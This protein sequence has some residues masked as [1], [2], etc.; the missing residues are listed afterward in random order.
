MLFYLFAFIEIGFLTGFI[1]MYVGTLKKDIN[2][3]KQRWVK[4]FF[5]FIIVHIVVLFALMSKIYITGLMIIVIL[6]SAFEFTRAWISKKN[7]RPN[8][9]IIITGN[10]VLLIL[11][12]S[13]INILLNT[14]HF[15]ALYVYTIIAVLDAYSQIFGQIFGRHKLAPRLSPNKTIE[16]LTGG[17]IAS[18]TAALL[19]GPLIQLPLFSRLAIGLPVIISGI[20]GDLLS[21]AFKRQ[22]HIKDYSQFLP[23]QGG[24]LDR[25]N[26]FLLAY[27][28]GGMIYLFMG[29]EQAL[30]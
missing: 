8:T 30:P 16:G 9:S 13:T 11:S 19:F 23:G 10:L 6:V 22:C 20:A 25:F 27:P 15:L 24:F 2:E 14:H 3:K 28:I 21:S 7:T 1:G 4:F 29:L 17:I 26:S 5:Y 18:F 12:T